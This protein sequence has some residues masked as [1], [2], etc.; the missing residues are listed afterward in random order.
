MDVSGAKVCVIGTG[1][2]GSAGNEQVTGVGAGQTFPSLIQ[3][4]SQKDGWYTTL[5]LTGERAL[6]RPVVFGGAVLFPTF[7]PDSNACGATGESYLYALY[8]LTGSAYSLPVIGKDTGGGGTEYVKR[9]T[10]LGTGMASEV[11]VHV[12]HGSSQGK[13][14]A[15]VQMST[16]GTIGID[17]DLPDG[18]IVSRIITWHQGEN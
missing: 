9:S 1:T 14:K 6:V 2:C 4:V 17:G 13:V 16:G 8:Y 10:A 5:P 7:V 11:A 3:M 18:A 12:G 15:F